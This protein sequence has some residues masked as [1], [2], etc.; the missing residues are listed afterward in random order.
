MRGELARAPPVAVRVRRRRARAHP[1]TSATAPI[2]RSA[3]C[4]S[5]W[6]R[7]SRSSS[8][9]T[10]STGPTPR[11]STCSARCCAARRP[12]PCCSRSARGRGRCRS[13]SRARSSARIAAGALT[14]LE[15]GALGRDEAAQLLGEA[16]SAALADELYRRERRQPLLPRAA[17][18]IAG[19]RRRPAADRRRTSRSPAWTCRGR[20]RPRSPRSSALLARHVAPPVRGRRRRR[21]IRSSPSWPPRR[22]RSTTPRPS[23]RSTTCSHATSSGE[24]TCRAASASATRWC[25]RSSTRRRPAAGCW[26]RTSAA[27]TRWPSAA[28]RRRRARTTSS[29]PRRPA[30]PR[31]WRSCD[32]AGGAALRQRARERRALVRRRSSRC[33]RTTLRPRSG[34]ALLMARAAALAASGQLEESRATLLETLALVPDDAVATWVQ[35]TVALRGRGAFPRP[36]RP[37][38]ETAR[39]GPRAPSRSRDSRGRRRSCWSWPSTACSGRTTTRARTWGVRALDAARPFGDRPLIATAGAMVIAGRSLQRRDRRRPRAC[40]PRSSR[41]STRC[42]TKSSPGGRT[43]P[44]TS[45]APS[46]TWTASPTRSLTPSAASRSRARQGRW[47]RRSMPTLGTARFMHGLLAESAAVLDVGLEN[48]RLSGIDAGDRVVAREPVDV[49]AGRRRRRD[50]AL[51][52]A[53]RPSS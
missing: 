53:R 29:T 43:P 25:G 8:C 52:R 38:P 27:R 42:R 4:S 3:S 16:A 2:A 51:D 1:R 35:L 26:A 13:A 6:P 21:A 18:A 10:T 40:W 11:R 36:P 33:F 9:S 41:S 32:E 45:A 23:R 28:P 44:G 20:W 19:P 12:P 47:R 48:A 14:R 22:P 17:R 34:W 50:G 30:T 31:R 46:S 24:P 15:L 49:G 39:R 5:D 7:P 37:C